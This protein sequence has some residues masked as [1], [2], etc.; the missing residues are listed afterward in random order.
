MKANT[1]FGCVQN[2]SFKLHANCALR[3][4]RLTFTNVKK[5]REEDFLNKFFNSASITKWRRRRENVVAVKRKE[6][7]D[8]YRD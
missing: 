1:D 4:L 7:K 8:M 5:K 3:L 2:S 6:V